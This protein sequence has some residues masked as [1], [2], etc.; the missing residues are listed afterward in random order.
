M[1]QRAGSFFGT[2]PNH[3]QYLDPQYVQGLGIAVASLPVFPYVSPPA[4]TPSHQPPE[5]AGL[6]RSCVIR[7]EVSGT[8]TAVG[9]SWSFALLGKVNFLSVKREIDMAASCFISWI[10]TLKIVQVAVFRFSFLILFFFLSP[11]VGFY[12]LVFLL[13]E[14]INKILRIPDLAV[15][16][17]SFGSGGVFLFH[18]FLHFLPLTLVNFGA[19]NKNFPTCEQTS[20]AGS[21]IFFI[22][23]IWFYLFH[24]FILFFFANKLAALWHTSK[25]S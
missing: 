23:A 21:T 8:P 4:T 25:L 15:G 16:I 6:P 20:F 1:R 18:F 5:P 11:I 22:T 12:F 3:L 2:S 17:D 14:L 19:A 9:S 7:I 10:E 13:R 24:F